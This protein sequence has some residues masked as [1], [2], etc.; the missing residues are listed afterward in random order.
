MSLVDSEPM[1][2]FQLQLNKRRMF[3]WLL[4]LTLELSVWD[5]VNVQDELPIQR[6]AELEAEYLTRPSLTIISLLS[7]QM[8]QR[9]GVPH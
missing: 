3:Q 5:Q 8:F 2:Y 1:L 7:V 4:A 6:Q 9:Q